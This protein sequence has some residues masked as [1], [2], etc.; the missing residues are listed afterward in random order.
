MGDQDLDGE[1]GVA[2][3]SLLSYEETGKLAV[4]RKARAVG[5]GMLR[6]CVD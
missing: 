1:R 2:N 4:R 5:R 6:S 3:R